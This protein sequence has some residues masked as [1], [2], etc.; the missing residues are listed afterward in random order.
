MQQR[1]KAYVLKR[2]LRTDAVSR[3]L[4]L[5]SELGE[6][7]KE[8]LRATAYGTMPLATTPALTEEVGDCLFS[9]LALCETLDISAEEALEGALGKYETRFESKGSI[10]SGQT[11]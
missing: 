8:V 4:D 3:L 5:T 10:G 2:N 9:L 7:A 1:V 6:V 11:R